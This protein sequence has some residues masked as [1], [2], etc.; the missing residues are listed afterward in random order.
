MQVSHEGLE[1]L[2][3]SLSFELIAVESGLPISSVSLAPDARTQL[4]LLVHPSPSANLLSLLPLE[5][6]LL[7]GVLHVH[8][9]VLLREPVEARLRGATVRHLDAADDRTTRGSVA[10]SNTGQKGLGL[11]PRRPIVIT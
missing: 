4:R 10:A 1:E 3:R 5:S 9:V 11:G 7:L 6:P 2:R 8:R